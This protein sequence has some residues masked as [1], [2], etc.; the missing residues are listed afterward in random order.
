V[1]TEVRGLHWAAGGAR[2]CAVGCMQPVCLIKC[3]DTAHVCAVDC[4]RSQ[5]DLQAPQGAFAVTAPASAAAEAAGTC[6][7]G[8]LEHVASTCCGLQLCAG[9]CERAWLAGGVVRTRVTH[10]GW[11][12]RT[13]PV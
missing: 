2:V 6:E 1:L 11:G 4:V 10:D 13:Q 3:T 12:T 5:H 9:V 7:R 8:R